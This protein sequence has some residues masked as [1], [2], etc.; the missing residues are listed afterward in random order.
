MAKKVAIVVSKPPYGTAV[1]GEA[2]R[3]AMGLP[4]VGIETIVV[5]EG[6]AV[7]ALLKGGNPKRALDMGN[8]GE[9]FMQF[10][11]Y[12]FNLFVHKPSVLARGITCEQMMACQALEEDEFKKMLREQ[13]AILRF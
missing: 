1:M 12:G 7:F 4:A 3:A 13:D 5:L 2:F 9:A 8:L 10:E 11:D 6:D